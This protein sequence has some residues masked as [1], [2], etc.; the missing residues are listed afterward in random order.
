MSSRVGSASWGAC[1]VLWGK[2]ENPRL[3]WVRREL[4][5]AHL[6]PAP[7]H[8]QGNLPLDQILA[9]LGA[10]RSPGKLRVRACSRSISGI[11]GPP[12]SPS[13]MQIS[14]GVLAAISLQLIRLR[15]GYL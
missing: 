3:V 7:W 6:V 5:Q 9:A 8:E 12:T 13:I 4:K 2:S 15:L 11:A 14:P 10:L 1:G